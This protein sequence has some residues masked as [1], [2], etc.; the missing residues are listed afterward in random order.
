MVTDLSEHPAR[1]GKIYCCAIWD[2]FSRKVVGWSVGRGVE[3]SL[4]NGAVDMAVQSRYRRKPKAR[5]TRQ[6]SQDLKDAKRRIRTQWNLRYW[7]RELV[8]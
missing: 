7:G 3:T 6:G 5:Q 8:L 2:A 4:V 1:E